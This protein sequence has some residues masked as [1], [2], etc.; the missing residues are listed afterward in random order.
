ME[1]DVAEVD[2]P[3]DRSQ[4]RELGL[5]V[6]A[7]RAAGRA[8]RASVVLDRQ[9]RPQRGVESVEGVEARRQLVEQFVT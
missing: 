6:H 1:E 4:M 9:P 7:R 2:V 8:V 3:G 5:E